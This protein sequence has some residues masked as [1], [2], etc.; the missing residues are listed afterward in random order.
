MPD[1]CDA[2]DERVAK[3]LKPFGRFAHHID[4]TGTMIPT[5]FDKFIADTSRIR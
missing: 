2:D 5:V 4:R 3:I 1:G